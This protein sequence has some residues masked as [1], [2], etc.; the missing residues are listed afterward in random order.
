MEYE[1]ILGILAPCGLNCYKCFAYSDGEIAAASRRL[2]ELLGS[3]GRYAER[4]SAFLPVF[5]NYPAF[6]E[7][8]IHFT[9]AD[10]R[11]CRE[12]DCKFPKCGVLACCQAK[13]IDFCFQ[14]NEFP[15]EK[16]NFDADLRRRWIQM[17]ERMKEVGVEVYFRETKDLPRYK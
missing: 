5:T 11:G 9:Q 3:F 8:L 10:C 2:Q 16:T 4:F 14:C 6:K 13:G 1:D 7:L 12:G 15:C 17:N